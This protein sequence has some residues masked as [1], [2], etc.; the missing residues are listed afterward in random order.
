MNVA[1]I[2]TYKEGGAYTHVIEL[3]KKLNANILIFT[4]NTKNFGYQQEDG[5]LYYHIPRMKNLWDVFFIN[6]PGSYQIVDKILREKN[7][8]I[9]HFH[10]PLFTF[11]HGILKNKKIPLIM[12]THYLLNIKAND[13]AATIYNRFIKRLSIY[14][15][16]NIDK[17]ICVNKDYIP[18][19]KKWGIDSDKLVYIPNGVDTKKFSI[20]DSKIKKKFKNKKIILYFGRLHYQKNVDLLIESFKLIKKTIKNVKLIII[21]TGTDYNK[22]QRMS[23]SDN[24]ILM[25]GFVPDEQLIDYIRAADIVVFPSR[26]ENASFTIM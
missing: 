21:G 11:S 8:D 16:K 15:A 18:V 10:S 19:F 23:Q 20:A 26:G 9:V 1:E 13:A 17:I 2:T 25:T 3:V 14:I 5:N 22:L 7:I 12:T 6:N 4:G 24:D